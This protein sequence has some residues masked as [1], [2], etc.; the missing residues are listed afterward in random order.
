MEARVEAPSLESPQATKRNDA[1][2]PEVEDDGVDDGDGED[3][4][5]GVLLSDGVEPPDGVELEA[6]VELL[7][8]AG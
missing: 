8:L 7:A 6:G 4:E 5:T 1:A 2:P 3:D